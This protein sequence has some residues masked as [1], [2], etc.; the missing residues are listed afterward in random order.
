MVSEQATLRD[1][2]KSRM[3]QGAGS[4]RC[5]PNIRSQAFEAGD[6]A[7]EEFSQAA[8]EEREEIQEEQGDRREVASGE[9]DTHHEEEEVPPSPVPGEVRPQAEGT[10]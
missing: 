10:R 6:A 1:P 2:I 3:A 4:S 9:E 5:G 7:H 8:S